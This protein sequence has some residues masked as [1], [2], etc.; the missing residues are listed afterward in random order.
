MKEG[1]ATCKYKYMLRP[2]TRLREDVCENNQD[3]VPL[4]L[5]A[6]GASSQGDPA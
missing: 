1:D 5:L 3:P 6:S 2:G 4:E